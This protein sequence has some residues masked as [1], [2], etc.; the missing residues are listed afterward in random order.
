MNIELL[1]S[2]A[3]GVFM[4]VV[5]GE[6]RLI[7]EKWGAGCLEF[8]VLKESS[9]DFKEGNCVS[10]KVNNKNMFYGY[11]FTKK[12]TKK[13]IISV[14]CYDQMRYLKNKDTYS[15]SG[16]TAAD[17]F[18]MIANDYNIET[19]EIDST[20]YCIPPRVED[21]T[22]LMDILYT[23]V[24][25]TEQNGYGRFIIYDDF[26]KLCLKS[27]KYMVSNLLVD[28][29]T[30]IDFDYQTTIDR[31]VYNKIK[32]IY[33][34]DTKYTH[35]LNVFGAQDD[36]SIKEWGVLQY[37]KHIDINNI[38]GN[39]EAAEL[40]KN[41]NVKNRQLKVMTFGNVNIRAGWSVKVE[42]DIGDFIVNE[43][44]IIKKCCHIFD[45]NSYNMELTLE[46]GVL[47]E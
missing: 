35:T 21:N 12:R 47:V 19:G 27:T 30:V 14:I 10:L 31:N 25:I 4:P 32:L 34:R 18:K 8:S 6:I 13:G 5:C 45:G 15:F 40:L 9:I 1:I 44:M 17:I 28:K 33:K 41:Y 20:G 23:A 11:V 22:T 42:L 3:K 38:D 39:T 16:Q 7:S 36:K 26:G 43:N 46:G 24:S 2:G 37:Y 29:N